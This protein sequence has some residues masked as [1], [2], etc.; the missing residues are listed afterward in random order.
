MLGSV[1][2][3]TLWLLV[4]KQTLRRDDRVCNA[5]KGRPLAIPTDMV[6]D[7]RM[8]YGSGTPNPSLHHP[9]AVPYQPVNQDT[10]PNVPQPVYV[11][12]DVIYIRTP[13]PERSYHW[14][15][16]DQKLGPCILRGLYYDE[17]RT[18]LVRPPLIDP[19]SI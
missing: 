10:N 5:N 18:K 7:V 14:Q 16:L 12:S 1:S 4:W 15:M 8:Y 19:N 6:S 3:P 17:S 9:Y 13:Q 11:N 2:F